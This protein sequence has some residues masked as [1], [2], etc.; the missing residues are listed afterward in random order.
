LRSL[1]I[2]ALHDF[3]HVANYDFRSILFLN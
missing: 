3:F 2:F 1:F